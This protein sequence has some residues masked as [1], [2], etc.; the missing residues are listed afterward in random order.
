MIK[1]FY[2][3]LIKIL[4]RFGCN[5]SFSSDGEDFVIEKFLKNIDS[6]LYVD[7]GSNHPVKHSN[8]F[9]LYLRGWR[10][11]CLD[12]IPNYSKKYSLYRPGDRFINAGVNVSENENINQLKFYFYQQFPD[13]S[14]FDYERVKHLEEVMNRKPSS[15]LDVPV[16]T[17]KQII[18]ELSAMV[19]D[20]TDIHFINVDI[21]GFEKK[22]INDIFALNIYPWLICVEELNTF[23]CEL[24]NG[25][26]YSLMNE[27]NYSFVAKTF[28]SSFYL[29]NDVIKK[30][31]SEFVQEFFDENTSS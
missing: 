15:I 10:G 2:T 23:A 29:R 26:I 5:L 4:R 3:Y 14:T 30:L 13:N 16:V 24:V 7:L 31:P 25:D 6:G 27:N 1:F 28:L 9:N 18:D 22:I 11:V 17:V 20:T 21:E 12:P 19:T 8:T